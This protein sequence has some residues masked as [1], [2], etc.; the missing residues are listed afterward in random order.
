[1]SRIAWE[2]VDD[3]GTP[4]PILLRVNPSEDTGSLKVT[5][6]IGYSNAAGP[7]GKTL[8]FEKGTTMPKVS[9]SGNVYT[10]QQYDILLA[11]VEKDLSQLTDDRSVVYSIYWESFTLS[12]VRSHKYP[13][14]HSYNLSGYVLQYTLP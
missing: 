8:I 3:G 1:M 4:N 7:G 5:K 2:F 14:K 12:R 10:E 11:E 13:W 9:F 6:D